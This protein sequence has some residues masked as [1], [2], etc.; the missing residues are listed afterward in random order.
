[1]VRLDEIFEIWYGVNLEVVN[2]EIVEAGM[3]FVSRQSINNG[4]TCYVK[5]IVGLSPNPAFTLSIAASGSVLSTFFHEC[6]YYSGR[7]VYVAKPRISLTKAEMLYYCAIIEQNKYRYNYGR[8]ANR[9]LR[10][11]IVPSYDEIPEIYRNE[12]ITTPF[13][14]EEKEI[15]HMQLNREWRWFHYDEIFAIKKGFY[16]K[17]PEEN[18]FG[19][20]PFIGATDSNNGITSMHTMQEI[21][22]ASKTGDAPNQDIE[23]KIFKGNCITVSNN[24]SIGYAFY[25]AKDFTCSHDVNPLYLK[26]QPMTKYIALFLCTLIELEQFRWAYGRK[27]RPK[28]MPSSLIKLPITKDGDPDW[29]FMENYIKSLPYSANI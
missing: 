16:N 22:L 19:T 27:W 2:C 15:H 3:P 5:P 28:R 10:N 6:E 13:S 17:K 23:E 9:T 29:Q 20:I 12:A 11:I 21:E 7:D 14:K 26:G 8:A 24:G 1:M 4:V 18:R 25:Q